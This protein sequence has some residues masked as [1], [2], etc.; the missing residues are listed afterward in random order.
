MTNSTWAARARR[1]IHAILSGPIPFVIMFGCI[2]LVNWGAAVWLIHNTWRERETAAFRMVNDEAEYSEHRIEALFKDADRTLLDLRARHSADDGDLTLPGWTE[3]GETEARGAEPGG[4]EAGGAGGIA[5]IAP[6][7]HV[8]ATTPHANTAGWPHLMARLATSADVPGA[9]VLAIGEP[10]PGGNGHLGFV[11]LARRIVAR[12]GG[13]GGILMYSLEIE[14]LSRLSSSIKAFD[15]CMTLIT[16]DDIILARTPEVR[17]TVGIR[18]TQTAFASAMREDLTAC[19]TSSG[20]HV[21]QIDGIDR[22]FSYRQVPGVPITL[23]VGVGHEAVFAGWR[24][25]RL[26]VIGGRLLATAFV[27]LT[28]FCWYSRR[29]QANISTGALSAILTHIDQGVRVETRA[30]RVVAVNTAGAAPRLPDKGSPTPEARRLDGS[31]IQ[32]ARHDLADGGT[33]LISTDL[34]ARHAAQARIDFLT[35]HDSLTGLPN[36]WRAA[37]LIQDLIAEKSGSSRA[38]ALIL[39][40]LD[41]FRDIN[42][43]MGHEGGDEVLT[44]VA[45]RLRDLV[46]SRDVVA[47]LGGDE[48]LLFLNDP[49]DE[50]AITSFARQ[51]PRALARPIVVRGQHLH[52]GAS[53]GIALHPRDGANVA[54]L[55][56]HANIAL[57]RA[58]M[59]GPWHRAMF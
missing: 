7:G 29:R 11:P 35:N 55:F 36:R 25:L 14:A 40:D 59:G 5:L 28:G 46:S 42:D 15:G 9:D 6:D 32:L 41:G 48:F 54:T 39:I 13:F 1:R 31:I 23:I 58:K 18:M 43:T 16:D 56:Q 26:T 49:D 33:I 20:R 8:I 47:R 44:E 3:P 53:L 45:D 17:G 50:A 22:I 34:T 52:L 12:D 38:A 21:S 57:S 10:I 30:G 51:L 2:V 19:G 24:S 37:S 4:T 27:L